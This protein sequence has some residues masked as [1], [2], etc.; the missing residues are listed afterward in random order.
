MKE[1][2]QAVRHLEECLSI[3]ES[4]FS[5]NADFVVVNHYEMSM[6]YC[7]LAMA[8]SKPEEESKARFYFEKYIKTTLAYL[9]EKE[10]SPT[11]I[12]QLLASL[13]QMRHTLKCEADMQRLD[14]LQTGINAKLKLK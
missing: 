2:E 6:I 5:K 12:E 1:P 10:E 8:Y 3:R 13:K 4:I 7:L 9:A 11:R 14:I